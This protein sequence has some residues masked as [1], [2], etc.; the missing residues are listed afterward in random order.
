MSPGKNQDL[1]PQTAQINTVFDH[2]MLKAAG[3]YSFYGCDKRVE[4]F[5]GEVGST[6]PSK[7]HIACRHGYQNVTKGFKFLQGVANYSPGDSTN[8]CYDGHPGFD[9][10]SGYGNQ[11]YA[12]ASGT[13]SYPTLSKLDSEGIWVGGHPD[14]LNTMELDLNSASNVVHGHR[15][16]GV[17]H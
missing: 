4:D 12:A 3:H 15:K 8:L 2:K 17:T 13:V 5:I 14:V 7:V 6:N 9:Y 16:T 1:T 11:V 10:Q